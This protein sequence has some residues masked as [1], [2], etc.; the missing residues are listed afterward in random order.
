MYGQK[1]C[2]LRCRK[3]NKQIYESDPN[4]KAQERVK[5][6]LKKTNLAALAALAF[7]DAHVEPPK[8]RAD[9]AAFGRL[10]LKETGVKL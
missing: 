2:Q 9:L 8:T 5:A 6:R 7:E 4:F 10:L 3:L 1:F